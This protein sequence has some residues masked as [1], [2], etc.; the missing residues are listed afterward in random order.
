MNISNK[1]KERFCKDYKIPI[2]LFDEPYF[3]ERLKL[4]DPYYDS[5]KHYKDFC[6]MLRAY[7]NEEDYNADYNRVKD[8]AINFIKNTMAYEVFNTMDMNAFAVTH[9]NLPH[10]DIFH[11]S[12]IGRSF[13]SLDMKKANFNSL[14]QI[15][16]S[17]FDDKETWEDF[18]RKFTNNE[19]IINSKYIREVILGN[20]NPKRH[21]TYEKYLMDRI[22][23]NVLDAGVDIKNIVFFSNDEIIIDITDTT[24]FDYENVLQEVINKAPVPLRMEVFRLRGIKQGNSIIGYIRDL[25]DGTLDLK[26]L[27]HLNIPYVLRTLNNEEITDNDLI[28]EHEGMLAKYLEKPVI[29]II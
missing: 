19:H 8:E 10:K 18:L 14:R 20:C 28:F 3:S 23:T 15:A 5:V 4:C 24:D 2:K 6:S 22:L 13:I 12:N 1:L 25:L 16:S 26:A 17:I 27:N 21:I 29:T 9:T 11:E 7:K